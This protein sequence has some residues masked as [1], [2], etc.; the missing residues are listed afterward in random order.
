MLPILLGTLLQVVPAD[1]PDCQELGFE[2]GIWS[3]DQKKIPGVIFSLE[4][5]CGSCKELNE[6]GL[7]E[8]ESECLDCCRKSEEESSKFKVQ[9]VI[10]FVNIVKIGT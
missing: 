10:D 4:L 8:L 5:E 1:R 9:I 3:N 7:K 6:F 2:Q